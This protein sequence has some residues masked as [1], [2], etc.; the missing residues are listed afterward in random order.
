MFRR[1]KGIIMNR[2]IY[3]GLTIILILGIAAVFYQVI[4]N[5]NETADPIKIFVIKERSNESKQE[6]STTNTENTEN[7]LTQTPAEIQNAEKPTTITTQDSDITSTN[8][9]EPIIGSTSVEAEHVE[10]PS[11]SPFGFGPYP[12]VPQDFIEKHGNPVWL[13]P[14][15]KLS[16]LLKRDLELIERVQIKKWIDGDRDFKGGVYEGGKIYLNYPDPFYVRYR[17]VTFPT[18][19][20]LRYISSALSGQKLPI[21]P[22]EIIEGKMPQGVT[23][24]DMDSPDVGI[25]PFEYLGL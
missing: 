19:K 1:G 7:P 21:S 25:D 4:R 11:E 3:W 9:S 10:V 15:D 12:E 13:R 2:K 6:E 14:T 22:E 5:Q 18:G 8:K 24:I 20:H 16:T 23:L 17:E